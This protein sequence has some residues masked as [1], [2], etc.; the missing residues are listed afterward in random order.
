MFV[1]P[2]AASAAALAVGLAAAGAQAQDLEFAVLMKTLANPFWGAMGE[3]V[4]DGMEAAG[5][6]GQIQAVPSEADVEPQLNTCLNMLESDPD[7]LITAAINS[8]NL[9]PCL[10]Q[11][12]EA[13]IPIVDLDG[14]LDRDM[15]AEEGIDIAFTIS[16]DN[17]LAGEKAARYIADRLGEDAEGAVLVIEGLAG[18]VTGQARRDGFVEGLAEFAPNMTIEASLPGD[19]D[20]L[21]A[22]NITND[23]LVRN[24]DL[25]AIY[26]AN[27]TMA[28]GAVEAV[29]GA[30]KGDQVI[31]VG[32]DG[33]ADAVSSIEQG[34]LDATV[35]QLPY[36]VGFRAV[37]LAKEV[38]EGGEVDDLVLV[39]TIVLDQEVL[40]AGEDPLLQYVR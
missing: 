5:V 21:K 32:T 13:G 9:L 33:N 35:A 4:E 6:G 40:E 11:A 30:G 17:R 23:M 1:R 37:E 8:V 20:R 7:A 3:G 10:A 22:A 27:D 34:R 12:T 31:V 25:A 19:W 24:P 28:L 15:A 29:F 39:D 38:V 14:N 36:L 2:L 18:N 26:A 16:S